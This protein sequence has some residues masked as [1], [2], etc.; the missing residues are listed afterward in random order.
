MDFLIHLLGLLERRRHHNLT[1]QGTLSRNS[2]NTACNLGLADGNVQRNMHFREQRVLA[3]W[4]LLEG[5][6]REGATRPQFNDLPSAQ[7]SLLLTCSSPRP[8][9]CAAVQANKLGVAPPNPRSHQRI[10]TRPTTKII[11]LASM[12][13]YSCQPH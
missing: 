6:I 8:L 1:F 3:S 2:T 9:P 5:D 13:K 7:I 11:Y 4:H 12:S 10:P